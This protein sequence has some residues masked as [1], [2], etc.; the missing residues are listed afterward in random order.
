MM[1]IIKMRIPAK[2]NTIMTPRTISHKNRSMSILD[3]HSELSERL[4]RNAAADVF[5]SMAPAETGCGGLHKDTE[6]YG[7]ELQRKKQPTWDWRRGTQENTEDVALR[8]SWKARRHTQV[9]TT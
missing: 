5:V 6:T 2:A 9:G 1:G 3:G 7:V 8:Q 4:K